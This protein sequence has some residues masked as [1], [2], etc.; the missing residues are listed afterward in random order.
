MSKF[1]VGQR[2]RVYDNIRCAK[3]TNIVPFLPLT[4]VILELDEHPL[5]DSYARIE[6]DSPA[7][8]PPQVWAN[9]RMV[10]LT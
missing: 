8:P 3:G 7:Y 1:K 9:L 2:V 6:V 5:G 10:E 4:G